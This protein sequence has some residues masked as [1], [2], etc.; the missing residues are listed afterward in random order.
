MKKRY[1]LIM[2]FT[3]IFVLALLPLRIITA[4]SGNLVTNG[5]FADG[6]NNWTQYNGD[7]SIELIGETVRITGNGPPLDSYIR[8]ENIITSNKNL[9]YCID[10]YP[11]NMSDS[12]YFNIGFNLWEEG[13]YIG[14][15]LYDTRS[16]DWADEEW[17]TF[18][19]KISDMWLYANPSSTGLPDFDRIDVYIWSQNQGQA[20][21]DNILL[22]GCEG[23][24]SGSKEEIWERD[25]EME[26]FK[27]WV[28][29]DNN[30]EFVFWWE[31][32]NNNWVQIYDKEGNLVW[33]IDFPYGDPRFEAGLPDGMYTVKTFHEAGHMLQEFM[34]RK[35]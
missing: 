17:T 6:L 7:G 34:I 27:V 16:D 14:F 11:E 25:H 9:V 15:S 24:S 18:C 2:S 32:Y 28:N 3:F 35:P 19:K 29:E 30:F 5:D 1:L 10:I 22:T 21:F 4:D 20:L 23:E 33:E 12:D 8:Q 13:S 31:Y 26:C